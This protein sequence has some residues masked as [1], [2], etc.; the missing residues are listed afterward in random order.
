MKF[1]QIE[2]IYTEKVAEYIAKGYTI[3]ASTMS[4]HQ[5]E[6]AKID[7]RKGD[8]IIRVM[9][10]TERCSFHSAVVI[11]VG[12]NTDER[13]AK[14]TELRSYDTI[15]NNRLEIIEKRIFWQMEKNYREVD[16]FLEGEEGE[17]ALEKGENRKHTQHATSEHPDKVFENVERKIVK[18]VKRHLNRS[19]FKVQNIKK[20]WKTWNEDKGGYEYRVQ[21]L[22]HTVT[23]A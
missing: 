1:R 7:L 2:A 22:K 6:I 15:W 16:F 11:I 21:T 18:A 19:S 4:G 3:N 13:I 9:L 8:E 17:K 20:V 10:D 14:S 5:G 12:R 23:L